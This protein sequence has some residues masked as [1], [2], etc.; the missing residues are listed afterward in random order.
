MFGWAF[1]EA[2]VWPV[3]PDVLLVP[4][5]IANRR[6]FYVP[7][8]AAI[9]G[10]ALGG[11]ALYLAA[12]LLPDPA[13]TLLQLLPLVSERQITAA[14]TSL[15]AW[16]AAALLAQPW[17]GVPLKVWALVAVMH[18][19]AP[20][21]AI[22]LFIGARAVRMALVALAARLLGHVFAGFIR[23]IWLYLAALYLG[24]FGVGWWQ[25]MQ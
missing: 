23:D 17:S 16:G 18:G 21:P 6:R 7:L 3:I 15:A 5:A 1:A 20:W 14:Q 22:P 9:A 4:M 10:S 13:G 25:L 8:G 24:L 2:M 11:T 19:I 12:T